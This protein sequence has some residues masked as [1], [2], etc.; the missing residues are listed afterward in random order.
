MSI[1]SKIK[2]VVAQVGRAG[3]SAK[4]PNE[5]EY[6]MLSLELVTANDEPIDYFA[7]PVMPKSI[8]K[9]DSKRISVKK[10]QSALTVLMS[11]SFTP[12][13]ITISGTFGRGLQTLLSPVVFTAIRYS[14]ESGVFRSYQIDKGIVNGIQKSLSP[15]VKTGFGALKILQAIIDKSDGV[16]EQGKSF[17]LYLYNPT[18]GESYLVVPTKN[19]LSFNQNEG[20]NNMIWEYTLNLTIIAP[21]DA[22]KREN[23]TSSAKL[24]S[25]NAVQSGVNSFSTGIIKGMSKLFSRG[26]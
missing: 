25:A 17:R 23:P 1:D 11:K 22:F 9:S 10:S 8:S 7:F 24:L 3:L 19:P 12:Q 15:Y 16:D 21:L 4:Y 2:E 20:G 18:L 14:T 13:D 5:F 26:S 6:Y